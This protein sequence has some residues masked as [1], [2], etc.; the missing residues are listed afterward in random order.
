MC[1]DLFALAERSILLQSEEPGK[2]GGETTI[3]TTT[4]ECFHDGDR[5]DVPAFGRTY[6]Q[7]LRHDRD[8]YPTICLSPTL[9]FYLSLVLVSLHYRQTTMRAIYTRLFPSNAPSPSDTHVTCIRDLL[10]R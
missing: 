2:D 7:R 1:R 10:E 9:F 6:N 3:T 8:D 4:A 5:E